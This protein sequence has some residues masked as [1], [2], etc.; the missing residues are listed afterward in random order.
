VIEFSAHRNIKHYSAAQ[1]T[2]NLHKM[3]LR[4]SCMLTCSQLS[5]NLKFAEQHP[6][7]FNYHCR[8][9]K[10]DRWWLFWW[11]EHDV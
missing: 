2:Q 9:L 1:P 10:L 8:I 6:A 5:P 11:G 4:C 7:A 3:R